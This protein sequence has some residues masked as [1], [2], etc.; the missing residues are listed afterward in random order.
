MHKFLVGLAQ[1]N[2]YLLSQDGINLVKKLYLTKIGLELLRTN[3][4]SNQVDVCLF[5]IESRAVERVK[6]RR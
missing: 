2:I 6:R 3:D 1:L 5:K 4:I